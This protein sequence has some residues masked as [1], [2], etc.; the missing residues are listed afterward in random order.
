MRNILLLLFLV[1]QVSLS[2]SQSRSDWWY[3]GTNAGIHFTTSD[4]AG[5]LLFYTDGITVFDSNHDIMPNGSGLFGGTSASNSA[6]IV[7]KPGSSTQFYIATVDNAGTSGVGLYFSRVDMTLNS[8]LGDVATSEKNVFLADS[9]SEKLTAIKSAN[10]YWI[11]SLRVYSDE[12]LAFE[13]TSSGFSNT[14]VVSHTGHSVPNSYAYCMTSSP[15]GNRLATSFFNLDSIY[16]YDFN[17][18]AG[19]VTSTMK[20]GSTIYYNTIYGFSFSP[21]S[22]ILYCQSYYACNVT[23]YDLSLGSSSAITAS[24]TLI[25]DN[26]SGGGALQ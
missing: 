16:L 11:V 15:D 7:P 18:T 19:T 1:L 20:I 14:P 13:V 5:N 2:F 9:T 17:K 10:G 24:E 21:N 23:Q 8:G 26:S 4:P 25:G 12:I 3:F 22:Q 6:V